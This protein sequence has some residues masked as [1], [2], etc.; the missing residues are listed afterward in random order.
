MISAF[1]SKSLMGPA[2]AI[3]FLLGVASEVDARGRGGG[4]RGGGHGLVLLCCGRFE[5]GL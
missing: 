2:I 5:S 4:G 3:V 1:G